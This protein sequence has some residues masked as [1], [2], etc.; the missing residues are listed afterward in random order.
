MKKVLFFI[1]MMC[2][3]FASYGEERRKPVPMEELT[4]FNSN[5]FVPHPYPETRKEI[6]TNMK[7]KLAKRSFDQDRS[8]NTNDL[9][10]ILEGNTCYRVGRIMKIY[11]RMSGFSHNY[12]WLILIMD[13]KDEIHLSLI[14]RAN[15]IFT[16][17]AGYKYSRHGSFKGLFKTRR[18]VISTLSDSIGRPVKLKEVKMERVAF[19]KSSIAKIW[20]PLWE[21]VLKDG[22]VYYYSILKN[23][24]YEIEGKIP[25]DRTLWNP[26]SIIPDNR[27]FFIDTI[28]DELIVL[29][30]L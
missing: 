14:E 7:F 5:F 21:I 2:I 1:F 25:Y 12:F 8:K 18:E 13:K 20:A 22:T 6:I 10:E 24:V 30:P 19:E 16:G 29:N 26:E 23:N 28:N 17:Y 27:D 9:F 11:N 3:V 15:G 4:G